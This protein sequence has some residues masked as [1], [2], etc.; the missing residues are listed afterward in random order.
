MDVGSPMFA[1]GLPVYRKRRV[2]PEAY[3]L[4]AHR[5]SCFARFPCGQVADGGL[6]PHLAGRVQLVKAVV[7]V[8]LVAT[9]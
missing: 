1:A 3:G 7:A 4:R 6:H 5:S 2:I 9:A 8:D